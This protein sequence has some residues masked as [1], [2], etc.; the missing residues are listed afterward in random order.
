MREDI[1]LIGPLA[2]GKTS[3]ALYLSAKLRIPNYPMDRIKWYYRFRNGYDLARGTTI[4]R[5]AG[6]G[7]LLDYAS[8]FFTPADME[9]FLSEFPN[10]VIDFGASQSV[11]EDP[12]LLREA[13]RILRPFTNI[14]LLLPSPDAEESFEILSQR[15]RERYTDQER[16]HDVVESYV[17]VNRR[18]IT[19]NSNRVLAK[20]TVYTHGMTVEETGE[21]VIRVTGTAST[22]VQAEPGRYAENPSS[23]EW[24]ELRKIIPLFT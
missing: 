6:F 17:E 23:I 5:T 7:A 12:G 3:V 21:A 18:F 1:V 20:H 4:L 9:R 11:I 15:I 2:V 16:S 22:S 10:G 24:S 19:C 8:A 13:K 14:V